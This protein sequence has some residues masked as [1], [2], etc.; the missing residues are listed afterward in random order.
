M[1]QGGNIIVDHGKNKIILYGSRGNN[2]MDPREKTLSY[3]D[4]EVIIIVDL[5]NNNIILYGS[6]GIIT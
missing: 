1:D 6:G 2:D 3:M 5:G 4:Q